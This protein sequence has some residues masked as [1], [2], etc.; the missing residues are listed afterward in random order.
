MV[1]A[2]DRKQLVKRDVL[3]VATAG[4]WLLNGMHFSPY[5]DPVL[6]LLKPF[7]S[8]R[9]FSTPIVVLYLASLI[10]SFLTLMIAG[11]PA[12]LTSASVAS[13][14][15]RPRRLASGLVVHCCSALHRFSGRP[16]FSE[17]WRSKVTLSRRPCQSR[18]SRATIPA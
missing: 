16:A 4:A 6:I 12:A 7:I 14:R 10:C 1:E 3:L 8:G 15:A 13:S 17:R 2:E 18:D 9:L 11:V 5:F